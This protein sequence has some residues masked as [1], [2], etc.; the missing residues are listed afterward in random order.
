MTTKNAPSKKVV[1]KKIEKWAKPV[2]PWMNIM[3][4]KMDNKS[5]MKSWAVAVSVKKPKKRK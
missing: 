1:V 3:A 4:K 5:A 2:L